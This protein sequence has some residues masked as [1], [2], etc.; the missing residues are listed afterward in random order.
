MG[1]N[2]RDKEIILTLLT[3]EVVRLQD[4]LQSIRSIETRN[5]QEQID[6]ASTHLERARYERDKLQEVV[7]RLA[8][9]AQDV[10]YSPE[11]NNLI[12]SASRTLEALA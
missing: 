11:L 5:A 4:E 10:G 6:A 7:L 3:K 2:N 1:L 12:F 8:N 9:M